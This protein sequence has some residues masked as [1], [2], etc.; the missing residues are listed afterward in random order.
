MTDVALDTKD[1]AR[2]AALA[3]ILIPGTDA[4]PAPRMIDGFE[5]LLKSAVVACGLSK[6][7]IQSALDKMPAKLDWETVR[8]YAA[9]DSA[10]F[11]SLALIA[12]GAY[13]MAPAVLE[14][15][16]FPADR[17]NPAGAMEAADEYETGILEPVINR[18]PCFR[19][20]RMAG[21]S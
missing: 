9:Q 2:L 13:L 1:L 4:M 12:G 21:K 5:A 16:G 19:D 3:E 14:K 6:E 15:L 11:E 8:K 20:P 18:G 17:R 10:H 7:E